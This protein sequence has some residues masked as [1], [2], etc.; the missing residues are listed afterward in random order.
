MKKNYFLTLCAALFMAATASAADDLVGVYKLNNPSAGELAAL[1]HISPDA[2][3]CILPGDDAA[4]YYLTGVAG[5][6][7]KF[8]MTY[9]AAD[10]TLT[11]VDNSPYSVF[12]V[13]ILCFGGSPIV[14]DETT[15]IHF[16]VGAD[17]TLTLQD[18]LIITEF[19][20]EDIIG[21]Y[22][23]GLTLKKQDA[24]PA[25]DDLVGDY[26]FAGNEIVN[27]STYATAPV[28]C[29]MS[30]SSESDG[31]LTIKGLLDTDL[32]AVYY[33]GAAIVEIPVQTAGEWIVSQGYDERPA[34]LYAA[35][36]VLTLL[37]YIIASDEQGMPVRYFVDGQAVKDSPEGAV[38]GAQAQSVAVYAYDGAVYVR[39][40]E[41]VAVQIYNAA[42]VQVYA[43]SAVVAP[44]ALPRGLY[45]VKAAGNAKALP[46]IL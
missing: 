35:D 30:V 38:A 5:F 33:P 24:T 46:V 31:R 14:V 13:M 15:E 4:D 29:Q 21:I 37:S 11:A 45:F 25:V 3:F 40:A 10:N 26:A 36:G 42:G 19:M 32:E 16:S 7:C 17:G 2:A 39:S 34:Y 6:G 20:G 12:G 18:E 41:P 27:L 8:P 22:S 43:D 44:I 9:N 23:Y 1:E 28:E